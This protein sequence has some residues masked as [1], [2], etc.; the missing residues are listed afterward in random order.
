MSEKLIIGSMP[1]LNRLSP[2]V[3]RQTLPVRSPLPNRH[4]SI[5]S[6]PARTAS[7]AS[8][9][10]VP[11]SLWVWT[12]SADVVPVRQV[13][14]HPLDLVGVD[15]RGGP[16][17]R[18][19][20]VEDDLAV[21]PGLPDVHDAGADIEREVQLGV[22]EDLGRVLVAEVGALQELLGVLHDVPGALDGERLALVAVDPEHH[23]AEDRGRRVVH[24]HGGHARADQRLDRAL[25]QVLASLGE[26]RDPDV[27]GDTVFFDQLADEVEV[28][29]AG[30]READLDLLVAQPDQ[31][32]EHRVLAGRAHR[33]D[34]RLV[35]VPEIGRQPARRR[36]DGLG[37]P[38]AVGEVDGFERHVAMTR[39]AAG[40]LAYG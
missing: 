12:D 20:Q 11:R 30:G 38:G 16:L 27:V 18:A 24:V 2:R 39:H 28:G 8:A 15:V 9:T 35:A 26:H 6:A 13:P 37:G 5:R 14:A 4:P 21:R 7:S 32:L 23:P 33:V 10:A 31:Q 19:R 3:T 22:H 36:G 34:Q 29:L 25:D 17:D 1:W 40:L